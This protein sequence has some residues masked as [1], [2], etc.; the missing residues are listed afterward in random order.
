VAATTDV[1]VAVLL[2]GWQLECC[3]TPPGRGDQVTWPLMWVDDASGPGAVQVDWQPE[4]LPAGAL[5]EPGDRVLRHGPLAAYW[6][7]RA[8]VPSRGCLLV[9][10]HGGVPTQVPP[11]QGTV[12]SIDV[13]DQGYRLS[14]PRTY[15]PIPGD[16]RLRRLDRSP[17]WF[18]S[19][20]TGEDRLTDVVRSTSGVLVG[21]AVDVPPAGSGGILPT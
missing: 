7:G 17:K 4:D 19:P 13:V 15:R 9:D 14:A 10:L 3:V 8:P 11:V 2:H 21:V 5:N 6:R 20:A 16:F 18:D 1:Q 12:V